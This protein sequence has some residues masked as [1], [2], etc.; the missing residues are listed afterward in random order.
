MQSCIPRFTPVHTRESTLCPAPIVFTPPLVH[1]ALV[2][3]ISGRSYRAVI[4]GCPDMATSISGGGI[5]V[6]AEDLTLDDV[7]EFL[8]VALR[9]QERFSA[10][11]HGLV[12]GLD[13]LTA[14][15]DEWLLQVYKERL[16]GTGQDPQARV[17]S[18]GL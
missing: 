7:K 6:P 18:S 14:G 16:Q 3:N 8:W 4:E 2:L 10:N 5:G 9:S 15:Q 12:E 1:T 17:P 11:L 13:K